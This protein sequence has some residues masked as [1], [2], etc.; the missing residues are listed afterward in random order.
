M[1]RLSCSSQNLFL[2]GIPNIFEALSQAPVAN[3]HTAE[4]FSG[5]NPAISNDSARGLMQSGVVSQR[6]CRNRT[7]I[8]PPRLRSFCTM[9]DIV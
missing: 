1:F 7:H 6:V 5:F 8:V 2:L 3:I 4:E 9:H